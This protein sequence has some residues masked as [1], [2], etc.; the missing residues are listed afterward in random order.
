MNLEERIKWARNILALL[1][2]TPDEKD[3]VRVKF[4]GMEAY[5]QVIEEWAEMHKLATTAEQF[6]STQGL[7]QDVP[8]KLALHF[9]RQG[10]LKYLGN[11]QFRHEL[12]Q[13]MRSQAVH[14]RPN[15]RLPG[16]SEVIE[17]V[18]GKQKRLEGEQSKSGFT[19]LLL[20][21]P[22]M[23]AELTTDL[24]KQALE[25]TPVKAVIEWKAKYLGDTVQAKRRQAFSSCSTE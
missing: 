5:R 17:S 24:V 22:A 16:S 25:S 9:R 8:L 15:E 18:F 12:L 4:G 11:R 7:A 2:R 19:G 10:Q 20:G 3:A 6:V 21:I 1:D 23:V 14:C 13:F